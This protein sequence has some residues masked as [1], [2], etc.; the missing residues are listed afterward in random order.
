MKILGRDDVRAALAGLEPAVLDS[1]RTAYLL[2]GQ[3][4]SHLPFSTFL[5]P[6]QPTGSR[7]I[8]LPA[9]LGGPEPVMGLKWIASFPANVDRGLQRAS[10]LCVLNDP[11]TGYPL[12]VLEGS[13]ISAAR[14]AAGAAL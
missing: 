10:A 8:S 14:T 4:Q 9:Y 13:Q 12:A 6:P 3:G 7:I 2:H 11:G 1:V 5:R